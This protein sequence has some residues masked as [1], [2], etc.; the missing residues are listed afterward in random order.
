MT[1]DPMPMLLGKMPRDECRSS[2]LFTFFFNFEEKFR[3][4]F[5]WKCFSTFY[6]YHRQQNKL[7]LSLNGFFSSNESN[8]NKTILLFQI[9]FITDDTKSRHTNIT[10]N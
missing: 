3:P 8:Y 1:P 7:E 10:T 4:D 9:K 6:F 5:C 2:E